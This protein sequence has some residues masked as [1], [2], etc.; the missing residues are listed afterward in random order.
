MAL[1][2]GDAAA[3]LLVIDSDK[4]LRENC[5]CRALA[6]DDL[7]R[8]P[9]ADAVLANLEKNHSEDNSYGIEL[10]YANRGELDQAFKWFEKAY[11]HRDNGLTL[12][13]VDPLVRNV[14]SDPRFNQLLRK[15]SLLN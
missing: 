13:K 3:A 4:R 7:G 6:Y 12:L 9:E 11:L 1:A 5:G 14:Q 15:L 8:R 10:V 2:R